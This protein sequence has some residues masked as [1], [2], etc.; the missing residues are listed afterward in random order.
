MKNINKVLLASFA[1]LLTISLANVVNAQDVQA[2]AN[3]EVQADTQANV[4][5]DSNSKSGLKSFIKTHIL[6]NDKAEA[7]DSA[8]AESQNSTQN[9]QNA[10]LKAR[11]N[12]KSSLESAWGDSDRSDLKFYVGTTDDASLNTQIQ[13]LR[14]S[15]VAKIQALRDE[16][17]QDIKSLVGDATLTLQNLPLQASASAEAATSVNHSADHSDS[18][19]HVGFWAKVKAFLGFGGSDNNSNE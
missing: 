19:A 2:N 14:A 18:G 1:F 5:Q 9:N 7:A 11:M 13:D 17:L 10:Q 3:V 12:E 8:E 15:Y 16:Y 6:S 4:Q